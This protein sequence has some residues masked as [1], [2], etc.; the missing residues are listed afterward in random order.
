MQDLPDSEIPRSKVKRVKTANVKR[1]FNKRWVV[2]IVIWTFVA[3]MAISFATDRALASVPMAAAFCIL[4]LFILIGILFDIIGVSVTAASEQPFH[5]MAANRVDSAREAIS[6]IRSAEK[7]SNLCN[8]V[9]GDIVG[10]IS[11]STGA[12]IVMMIAGE[13]ESTYKTIMS[14]VVTAFVASLTIG[15][16]AIGKTIAMNHANTIIYRV[17]D[18]LA[19]FGRIFRRKKKK[20]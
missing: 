15:G 11:G 17:A 18:V 4:I 6:L 8:D 5:S 16:K 7:V 20:D 9:V 19:F 10:I 1:K 2:T 14:L 3:S 12:I 13:G